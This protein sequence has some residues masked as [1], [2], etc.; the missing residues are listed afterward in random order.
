MSST[1]KFTKGLIYRAY[2]SWMRILAQSSPETIHSGMAFWMAWVCTL[3]ALV[4]WWAL[5]PTTRTSL[6]GM[7]ETLNAAWVTTLALASSFASTFALNGIVKAQ[8]RRISFRIAQL[9]LGYETALAAMSQVA[10][11]T[12][13]YVVLRIGAGV[14]Y[15]WLLC[16]AV[17]TIRA[18]RRGSE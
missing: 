9:L 4:T 12:N 18:T 11:P 16:V 5:T 14:L 7:Q 6:R 10:S 1:V 13:S 2:R 8:N 17:I 15:L 3:L